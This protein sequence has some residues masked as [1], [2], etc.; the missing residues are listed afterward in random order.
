MVKRQKLRTLAVAVAFFAAL[1]LVSQ[2]LAGDWKKEWVTI[3]HDPANSRNQPQEK[4][5][6]PSNVGGLTLN[7]QIGAGALTAA[8]LIDIIRNMPSA[9]PFTEPKPPLAAP[10]EET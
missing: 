8:R 1:A 6:D 9:F 4:E 2:A 7:S 3:G 5:I 10:N